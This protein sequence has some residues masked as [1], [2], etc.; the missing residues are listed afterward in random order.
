L[1]LN[2]VV[3]LVFSAAVPLIAPLVAVMVVLPAST[4]VAR[5]ELLMVATAVLDEVQFAVLLRFCV[6]PS[7]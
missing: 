5:P 3:L 7:L 6:V 1:L 4:L 2:V